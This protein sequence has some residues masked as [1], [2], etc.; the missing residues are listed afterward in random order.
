MAIANIFQKLR[1]QTPAFALTSLLA[2][3]PAFNN[4]AQAQEPAVMK[5]STSAAATLAAHHTTAPVFTWANAPF[6]SAHVHAQKTNEVAFWIVLPEG[7]RYTPE[8]AAEI[9]VTQMAQRGIPAHAFGGNSPKG[10][11]MI[12]NV[13]LGDGLYKNPVTGTTDFDLGNIGPQLDFIAKAYHDRNATNPVVAN[14]DS[15]TSAR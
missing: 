3:L 1:A 10:G 4:N 13:F 6:G 7:A 14:T 9:L 2:V 15:P 11:G 5:P 12:V 8:R